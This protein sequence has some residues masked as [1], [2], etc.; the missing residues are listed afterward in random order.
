MRRLQANSHCPILSKVM[1][2]EVPEVKIAVVGL[3]WAL[4]QNGR[5]RR[6]VERLRQGR[7]IAHDHIVRRR[8]RQPRRFLVR[9]WLHSE[10]RLQ[11][12]HFYRLMEELRDGDSFRNFLRME[13]A[14]FDELPH[15]I[16]PRIAKQDTWYCQAIEPGIK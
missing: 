10:R 15:R 14:M 2:E 7:N 12:G 4:L 8:G 6:Q 13:P 9:P 5:Q 3:L 11:F 1:D 16:R